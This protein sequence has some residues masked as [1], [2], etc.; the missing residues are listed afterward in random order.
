MNTQVYISIVFVAAIAA[1]AAAPVTQEPDATIYA[2]DG[3]NIVSW[4]KFRSMTPSPF[5]LC[6]QNSLN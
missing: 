4:G 3:D 2:D 5:K 6:T 1:V